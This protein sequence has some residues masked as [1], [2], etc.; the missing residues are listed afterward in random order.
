MTPE[1]IALLDE[2]EVGRVRRDGRG[3]FS[4][5]YSADWVNRPGA[6]PMSVTMP[7]SKRE[8]GHRVV[9]PFLLNL[10]P[11]DP[12]IRRL[13]ATKRGAAADDLLGLLGR[14]A[15]DCAGAVHFRLP[16]RQEAP[17]G[18]EWLEP[19]A[20][21]ERLRGLWNDASAGRWVSDA[22]QF[23]LAGVQPK[24]A[25]YREGERWG[26]PAGRI[27]TTHILKVGTIDSAAYP[28]NEHFCLSLA[29]ALGLPVARSEVVEFVDEVAIAVER[30][31]RIR[32]DTG[33]VRIHQEDLCQ[34]LAI[35]P[36]EKY[37]NEGGPGPR[38]IVDAIRMYC[39]DPEHDV[40]N[41]VAALAY[42]WVV[43]GTDAHAKNYSLRIIAGSQVS[44]APLYDVSSAL[45]YTTAESKIEL[46]MAIGGQYKLAEIG[47]LQWRKLLRDLG[48]VEDVVR[49]A[50]I[51]MADRIPDLA[52]DLLVRCNANG[53]AHPVLDLLASRVAN[54]S[55]RCAATLRS[56]AS[57]GS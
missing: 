51:E 50:M 20:I 7:L 17:D 22:G 45:P 56:W 44:H 5:V 13:W 19:G 15:Q 18:V 57:A 38:K 12:E 41:F 28:Q 4:L 29:A 46:S 30:F 9:E 1:L 10:L 49:S 47:A 14:V 42:N 25:L 6:Y 8:H 43:G 24:T 26:I 53:L 54:R 35:F 52:S 34:A 36:S 2:H 37:E 27:P 32:T 3:S 33:I 39:L 16:D 48:L 40:G 23:S 11:D 31:D 55:K 21:R